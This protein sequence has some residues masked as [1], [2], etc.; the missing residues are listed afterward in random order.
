[1]PTFQA[2]FLL[3]AFSFSLQLTVS[4]QQESSPHE[5]FEIT[6]PLPSDELTP[7]LTHTI[8]AHS[9]ELNSNY[10]SRLDVPYSP[11]SDCPC[12]WSYVDLEFTAQSRGQQYARMVGLWFGGVELLRTSTAAPTSD[13]GEGVFWKVRKDVTRY[14]SQLAQDVNLTVTL[15]GVVDD[16][17]IGLFFVNVSLVFYK[18]NVISPSIVSATNLRRNLGFH[19]EKLYDPAAD[20]I[21]PVSNEGEKGF[22]FRI[23]NQY[24]THFLNVSIPRN[25]YKVI[26]ELCASAHG[27]D[28]FWYSNLPDSYLKANN[29]TSRRGNGSYREVFVTI[30]GQPIGSEI[31]YPI[32][33]STGINSLFWDPVVAIGAFDIPTYD[34]ELTP[35][36]GMLLDGE[37]HQFGLGVTDG[38]SYWLVNANLHLWLDPS[39]PEVEAGSSIKHKPEVEIER[40][41]EYEGLKGE[42]EI[43]MER[44]IEIVGWVK[45]SSGNLTTS[46]S[47]EY[48]FENK[49]QIQKDGTYMTVRQKVEVEKETKVMDENRRTLKKVKTKRKSPLSLIKT[50]TPQPMSNG[51]TVV[52]N[53]TQSLQEKF[54]SHEFSSHVNTKQVSGGWMAYLNDNAVGGEGN[55]KQNYSYKGDEVGCYSRNVEASNGSLVK[56]VTA[57]SCVTDY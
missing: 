53:L 49:I 20:L 44:E 55:T 57:N 7:F 21:V 31:P 37:E 39:L 17:F 46:V 4:F 3:L 13:E 45:T 30:D 27:D 29:L 56:D 22:W 35:L 26:L 40:E 16:K 43:E 15:D 18:E 54:S 36:L 11:P 5:L 9:F 52:S 48:E 33:Y 23:N 2:L 10:S 41:Y 1:M 28:E 42:F 51:F 24:N 12:C 34:I 38:I 50:T 8:V 19:S 47:S 14:S 25:T 32:V 6:H